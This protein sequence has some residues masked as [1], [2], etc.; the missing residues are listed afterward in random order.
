MDEISR[1]VCR[2]ESNTKETP[3]FG[4]GAREGDQEEQTRYRNTPI[5]FEST[6]VVFFSLPII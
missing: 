4:R 2:R 6:F 3:T 1:E 5:S